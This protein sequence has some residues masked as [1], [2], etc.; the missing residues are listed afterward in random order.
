MR[1]VSL[2]GPGG[3][4]KTRLA[5]EVAWELHAGTGFADGVWFVDLASVNDPDLAPATVARA[6][7]IVDMGTGHDVERL[8]EAIRDRDM[9]LVLDNF[10]QVTP[11]AQF[12]AELLAAAPRLSILV[13][14]RRPLHLRG[15]HEIVVP[16]L[17]SD[18]AVALFSARARAVNP[19]FELGETTTPIVESICVELDRLPLAIELAAARS[20][21]L[22]PAELHSRLGSRLELLTRGPE[23]SAR[24]AAVD[25]RHDLVELRR[26]AA[27]RAEPLPPVVDVLGRL[28]P[29][30]G[31]GGLRAGGRTRSRRRWRSC[32][33]TTSSN[34]TT[35]GAETRFGMFETVR[36]FGRHELVNA[37]DAVDVARRHATYFLAFAHIAE[38]E[39]HKA[40]QAAWL[41][42]V[43]TEHDNIRAALHW[44]LVEDP[45]MALDLAGTMWRF[46][47]LRGYVKEGLGW[48]ERSISAA[49]DS[50]STVRARAMLGA[51]SMY[52]AIGDDEAAELPVPGGLAGLG[53]ARR[54]RWASRSPPATSA[55][56][57]SGVAGTPRRPSGTRRPVVSVSS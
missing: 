37:A 46:W 22:S 5:V 26:V 49:D 33:T 29:G 44:A 48:L 19:A 14:S 28:E 16:P 24:A 57:I 4:G 11:A 30:G 47:V 23:R 25:A 12:V 1:L 10:E 35:S 17:G 53:G 41:D 40:D 51:G 20:K 56:P 9:L 2:L 8:C 39:F 15:E 52:E 38:R 13:T 50:P 36:E 3:I 34:A 42:R 21:V 32:S 45:E 55:T 18:D 43:A 7:G 6:I 54:S 31:G 27:G